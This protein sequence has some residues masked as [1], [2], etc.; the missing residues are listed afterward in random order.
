MQRNREYIMKTARA[1]TLIE[2]LVVFAV[3]PCP[4]LLAL[5]A[6]EIY[7]VVADINTIERCSMS[8]TPPSIMS[9]SRRSTT[10]VHMAQTKEDG[11][12]LW[13]AA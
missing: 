6:K 2:L 10:V 12:Y 9:S 13:D 4:M 7:R 11:I 5:L 1:F 3:I 8:K